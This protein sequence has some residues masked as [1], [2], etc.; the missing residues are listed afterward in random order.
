MNEM[1]GYMLRELNALNC[2]NAAL[3]RELK[4]T[5]RA[6][7]RLVFMLVGVG[8]YVALNH[9]QIIRRDISNEETNHEEE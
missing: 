2:S 7:R 4:R 9:V 5:Q 8:L 1:M 6:N 3:V